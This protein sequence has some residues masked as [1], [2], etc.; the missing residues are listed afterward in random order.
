MFNC[1]F[2]KQRKELRKYA[3]LATFFDISR[4]R[5]RK[6]TII[7][8]YTRISRVPQCL[9]VPSSELGPS[10]PSPPSE[11]VPH[12]TK[13][14]CGVRTTGEKHSTLPTLCYQLFEHAIFLLRKMPKCTSKSHI[15][16]LSAF[17][18]TSAAGYVL[19][20]YGE[21]SLIF[22]CNFQRIRWDPSSAPSCPRR[23]V[24]HIP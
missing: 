16:S 9:S 24:R 18:Y 20:V 17:N 8:A 4:E 5:H 23:K 11:S 15:F 3:H 7:S 1:I 12:G 10:T 6:N 21:F 14:G 2:T 13:G 22:R 19:Y